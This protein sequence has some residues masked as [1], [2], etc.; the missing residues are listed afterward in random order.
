LS[1]PLR[2]QLR[3]ARPATPS[4]PDLRAEPHLPW[5]GRHCRGTPP[6]GAAAI[7]PWSCRGF[8]VGMP[9][10]WRSARATALSPIDLPSVWIRRYDSWGHHHGALHPREIAVPVQICSRLG[11]GD[12]YLIFDEVG[13]L[14][15][16]VWLAIEA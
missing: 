11:E 7:P 14:D 13:K 1:R 12:R 10:R 16:L 15:A 9:P 8:P 6:P 3:R 5:R 2:P 4:R